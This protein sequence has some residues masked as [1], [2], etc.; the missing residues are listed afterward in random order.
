MRHSEFSALLD[1]ALPKHRRL[2]VVGPPGVG[3]TFAFLQF[4]QRS[5]WQFIGICSPLEDPSTIRG[6]PSRGTNG[7]ATHCLFDG[8]AKA[9]KAT[10]PTVL[11]FD[12]LGMASESTLRSIV[13]LFQFGEID[14]RRL[15]DCVVLAAATNDVGHGAG[16]Y[17]MIEPLKSRFHSIVRIDTHV[18]D[19]VGYGLAKG[20]PSDLC[21][22]LRNTPDALHDWKPE[23]TMT[24]GGS[25][26]RG[27]EYAAEWVQDGVTDP[28]VIAGCV[29]KGR[30]SQ[31]LA[32]R[33][34]INEL[35]DIDGVLM[36]PDNAPIPDNPSARF[37]VST[38]LA[39]RMTAG[40]FG[41][42]VT[43][44]N[45]LPA[46]FRA[47]S[48]RDAF[49][50]EAFRRREKTLPKDWKALSSSRDFTAWAVSDDGKEVMAAAS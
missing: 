9:F 15:P 49:R 43:Y 22:F 48:I 44:L 41:R 47:Y 28:E 25:C 35:T 7:E 18:D 30:A 40:N 36:D 38:C 33:E 16:V 26:P 31:Y 21:A 45:R 46:M 1:R 39:A 19:V 32:F 24:V 34:L 20:W 8:I 37:L 10:E 12:D 11:L 3:K 23:K 13:R 6:Y 27:W 50:A 29:G 2:M 14:N 42:A 5:S 4:C 17:G